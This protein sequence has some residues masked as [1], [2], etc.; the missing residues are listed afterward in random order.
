MAKQKYIAQNVIDNIDG[1]VIKTGDVVTLEAEVAAAFVAGGSL[2]PQK[3][4]DP[5]PDPK[6]A[7]GEKTGGAAK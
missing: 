5:E 3:A 1:K 2:K 7:G 4:A 6:A